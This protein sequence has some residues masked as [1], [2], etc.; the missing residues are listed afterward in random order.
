MI[1]ALPARPASGFVWQL[2]LVDRRVLDLAEQPSTRPGRSG[3]PECVFSFTA[4]GAG[5]THLEIVLR[6]PWE[7]APPERTFTLEVIVK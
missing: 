7:S 6:R 5:T 1:A 4:M 2:A 3:S